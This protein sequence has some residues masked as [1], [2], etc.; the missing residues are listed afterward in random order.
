MINPMRRCFPLGI[1]VLL[2]FVGCHRSEQPTPTPSTPKARLFRAYP[3][4][5]EN[6]ACTPF[7]ESIQPTLLVLKNK[8]LASFP[9]PKKCPRFVL[10]YFSASWCPP[11]HLFTP[12]LKAWYLRNHAKFPDLEVV[13]ASMDRQWAAMEQYVVETGMP[14]PVLAWPNV[15]DS[16]VEKLLPEEIPY[17]VLVDDEGMVLFAARGMNDSLDLVEKILRMEEQK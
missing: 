7:L 4:T 9:K 10:L 15:M 16:P 8:K 17:L 14:W 1:L 11:C 5:H 2:G 3:A 6:N 12:K 13:L